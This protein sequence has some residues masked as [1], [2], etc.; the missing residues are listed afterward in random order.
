MH[1]I[2]AKLIPALKIESKKKKKEI[3][4]IHP[5]ACICILVVSS[6]EILE[7]NG[8]ACHS[9]SLGRKR[10]HV[11]QPIAEFHVETLHGVQHVLNQGA[12]PAYYIQPTA[13]KTDTTQQERSRRW[14]QTSIEI[15][16]E[17]GQTLKETDKHAGR[18]TKSVLED[19]ATPADRHKVSLET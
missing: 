15:S 7:A 12:H 18:E 2:P 10:F 8:N 6:H 14:F 4:L 17:D 1:P 19:I 3:N 11:F 5:T 13:C 16:T 9:K